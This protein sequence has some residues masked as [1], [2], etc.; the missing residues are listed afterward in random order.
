[1]LFFGAPDSIPPDTIRCNW[2]GA[3]RTG[4]SREFRGVLRYN[5]PDSPAGE[6]AE[7]TAPH[8]PTVDCKTL[9]CGTMPRQKLERRS[10]RSP[11]CPV[12]QKDKRLQRSTTLNPNGCTDVARTRLSGAP[13]ASSLCQRLGS[14]WGL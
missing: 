6:P 8:V 9:Q 4:H 3:L 10:Q 13:I 1:M 2:P 11:D 7:Q 5:S 12:Q 14:G